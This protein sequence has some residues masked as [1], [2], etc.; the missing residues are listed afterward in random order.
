MNV[1]EEQLKE[2]ENGQR[3]K[4]GNG[5]ENGEVDG[6]NTIRTERE[7]LLKE[8]DKLFNNRMSGFKEKTCQLAKQESDIWQGI[9]RRDVWKRRLSKIGVRLKD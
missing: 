1:L 3:A 7:D 6:L 4:L 9:E 5:S 2:A 8:R